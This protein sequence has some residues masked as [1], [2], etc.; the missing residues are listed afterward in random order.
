M[1]QLSP[2]VPDSQPLVLIVEDDDD[3]RDMMREL[4]EDE[5][6]R[7][8]TAGDGRDALDLIERIGKPNVILLDLMMPRMSGGD[9]LEAARRKRPD[10]A[11]VP[12]VVITGYAQMMFSVSP[13]ERMLTKPVDLHALLD[14]VRQ[15]CKPVAAPRRR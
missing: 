3:V 8:A 15:Y 11:R 4:F 12:V 7:V 14:I 13:V 10:L 5:G 2:N 1:Q 9:F 6:Y